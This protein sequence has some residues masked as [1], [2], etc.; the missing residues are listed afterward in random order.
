M[1]V[2]HNLYFVCVVDEPRSVIHVASKRATWE[3]VLEAWRIPLRPDSLHLRGLKSEKVAF[4]LLGKPNRDGIWEMHFLRESDLLAKGEAF[5]I[6]RSLPSYWV[7]LHSWTYSLTWS[8]PLSRTEYLAPRLN[9]RAFAEFKHLL[10]GEMPHFADFAVHLI[11]AQ[12]AN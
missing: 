7:L 2:Q 10:W 5:N 1:T 3:T 12:P 4:P 8:P 6:Q 9:N 11:P